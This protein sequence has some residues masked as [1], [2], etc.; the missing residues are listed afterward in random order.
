[1]F[2]S[3]RFKSFTK[4]FAIVVIASLSGSAVFAQ[5]I[6]GSWQGT[7]SAGGRDLRIVA[8]ISNEAGTLRGMFYSIDQPG[9]G[10][11]G[12]VTVQSA[13]VKMA[14]PGVGATYDGKLEA[15][16]ASINPGSTS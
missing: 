6:A 3:T 4:F 2:N 10:I 12:T 11:A 15:D 5:E 14:I 13:S 8:K 9:P 1:M 16:G 7:L